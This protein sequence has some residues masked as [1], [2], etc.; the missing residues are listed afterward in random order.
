MGYRSKILHN[1]KDINALSKPP[2][3]IRVTLATMEKAEFR[4]VSEKERSLII[5]AGKSTEKVRKDCGSYKWFLSEKECRAYMRAHSAQKYMEHKKKMLM[6]EK[7][8][9]ENQEP[10]TQKENGT[11]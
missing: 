7:V 5:V 6:Y 9:N 10:V 1:N 3:A 8:W 11:K 4:V 2:V